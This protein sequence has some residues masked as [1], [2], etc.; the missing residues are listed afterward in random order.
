MKD[1]MQEIFQSIHL[2]KR[3]AVL[4]K[5]LLSDINMNKYCLIKVLSNIHPCLIHSLLFI[6]NISHALIVLFV[7]SFVVSS[8][9]PMHYLI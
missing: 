1:C 5:L 2:V 3:H 6:T 8:S 7:L 4:D 9:H